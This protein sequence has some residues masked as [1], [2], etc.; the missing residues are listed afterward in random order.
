MGGHH[1]HAHSVAGDAEPFVAGRRVV[2]V[3]LAVLIPILV[4]TAV[5]LVLLW[6]RGTPAGAPPTDTTAVAGDRVS[7]VVRSSSASTCEGESSDRLADGTVPTTALCATVVAQLDSGPDKGTDVTVN[8]P[9]QVYKAGIAPGDRIDLTLFTPQDADEAVVIDQANPDALA[10][11][12]VYAWVDYSR[13]LPLT[14][15]AVLFAVLVTAVARFRGLAAIA[16]LAIAYLTVIKFMLPALRLGENA[17]AVA[18]VGSIAVMTV[19]LYLAHGI[20]AKT[21]TA[22]LGTIFGLVLTGARTI[23]SSTNSPAAWTCPGSLSAASSS[24][25]SAC[26]TT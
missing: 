11:G 23:T 20:N 17:V 5:A 21:T 26:S 24:P 16:G 19:V 1:S 18:V 10:N 15:L 8:I 6:P 2:V 22:L 25:G 13:G 9:P 14:V 3:L 4:A 7:A 12:N